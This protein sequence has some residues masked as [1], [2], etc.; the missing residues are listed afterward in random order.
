MIYNFFKKSIVCIYVNRFSLRNNMNIFFSLSSNVHFI[1][2]HNIVDQIDLS[3][4][5]LLIEAEFFK[6]FA[7]IICSMLE[8]S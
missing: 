4:F 1:T 3:K 7:I 6:E 2:I 5:S 8:N